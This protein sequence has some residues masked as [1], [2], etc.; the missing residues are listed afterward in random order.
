MLIAFLVALSVAAQQQ[1]QPAFKT[2]QWLASLHAE[3][4]D[5]AQ[6]IPAMDIV[7]LYEYKHLIWVT[8]RIY[9]LSV[10]EV[11]LRIKELQGLGGRFIGTPKIGVVENGDQTL[12]SCYCLNGNLITHFLK[13]K[14]RS[15]N[16]SETW[17]F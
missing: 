16:C 17:M 6:N 15:C 7:C 4:T 1:V 5:T 13:N 10:P 8:A 14:H 3:A 11:I 12:T 9:I 2:V